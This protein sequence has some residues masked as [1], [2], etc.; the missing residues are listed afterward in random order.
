MAV[1]I[2]GFF[3]NMLQFKTVEIHPVV[4]VLSF[5]SNLQ[6]PLCVFSVCF[7]TF[8]VRYFEGSLWEPGG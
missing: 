5:L 1:K 8:S 3:K 2:H 6:L 7:E 4:E